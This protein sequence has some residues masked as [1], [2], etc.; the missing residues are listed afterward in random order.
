MHERQLLSV[1]D[2]SARS[3]PSCRVIVLQ[4]PEKLN[5]LSLGMLDGLLSA[6][7]GS[8]ADT[9]VLASAGRSFCT[10]LDL[11]EIRAPANAKLHLER[12][13]S[14]YRWLLS[15]K[16][17]TIALV[18]GFAAGGG[19]GLMACCATVI[20]STEAR[21]RLPAGEL[22]PLASVVLPVFH[23]KAQGK[24]P[25][26]GWLGCD[27]DARAAHPLG[28]IDQLAPPE[29]F[30]T[31]LH[32]ARSGEVSPEWIRPERHNPADLA[33]ALDGLDTFLRG[34]NGHRATF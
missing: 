5:C 32:Q 16:V 26:N 9:V 14:V 27:L 8:K 25:A 1:A 4:R 28:L 12:L 22:A 24:T 23:L 17:S 20:A 11:R 10:G 34:A 2:F 13:V 6:L 21:I 19:A 29:H 15:T 33:Q 31:L 30:E 18:K 3:G 7:D